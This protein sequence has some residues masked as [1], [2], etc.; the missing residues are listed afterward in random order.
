MFGWKLSLKKIINLSVSEGFASSF[1]WPRGK[2]WGPWEGGFPL[3]FADF[4]QRGCA[5]SSADSGTVD[6]IY[7]T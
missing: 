1:P 2:A 4:V 3:L 6:R 5:L 7:K